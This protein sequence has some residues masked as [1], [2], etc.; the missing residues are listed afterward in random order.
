ML[1]KYYRSRYATFLKAIQEKNKKR[2]QELEEIKAKEEKKKAKLKEG[3]GIV[4]VQSRFMEDVT[5]L[6]KD[7]SEAKVIE[8][9][10]YQKKKESNRRGSSITAL[11]SM[12]STS[13][14]STQK[15]TTDSDISRIYQ[16]GRKASK[17]KSKTRALTPKVKQ[18]KRV[19]VMP[20]DEKN[21]EDMEKELKAKR[22]AAEKIKQR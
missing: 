21:E 2:D 8:D 1:K 13:S 14:F 4:N 9:V 7:V 15:D 19:I 11:K 22:E 16:S 10:Q 18:S 17:S 3:L 20:I 6:S 5:K 12:T